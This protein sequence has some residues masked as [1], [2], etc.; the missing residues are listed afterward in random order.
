MTGKWHAAIDPNSK[1]EYYYNDLTKKTTWD[2]P[3]ELMG[4]EEA[5]RHIEEK[6]KQRE[7]FE[8]M[9]K[10]ILDRMA[11]IRVGRRPVVDIGTTDS[12]E[13]LTSMDG[14]PVRLRTI[15]PL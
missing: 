5:Q 7:F 9:E 6:R 11:G 3:L 2:K 1:R 12:Y 4:P 14:P 13:D 10:N 8:A 15:Y